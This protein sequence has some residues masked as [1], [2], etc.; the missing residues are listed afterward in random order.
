MLVQT[1]TWTSASLK[2]PPGFKKTTL[3]D[4]MITW[5]ITWDL[6]HITWDEDRVLFKQNFLQFFECSF[7]HLSPA[8]QLIH[9][10]LKNQGTHRH[11]C[12]PHCSRLAKMHNKTQNQPCQRHAW[13]SARHLKK[14]SCQ[15]FWG[16]KEYV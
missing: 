4:C 2:N 14:T 9:K 10:H 13:L 11:G 5:E 6:S 3:K 16:S 15:Y 7:V 12:L 1:S 8:V